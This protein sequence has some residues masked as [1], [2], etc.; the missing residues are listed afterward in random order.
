MIYEIPP[1]PL[2]NNMTTI[3]NLVNTVSLFF[4]IKI[5]DVPN[6]ASILG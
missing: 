3:D 5:K 6:K 1:I 2:T 4:E